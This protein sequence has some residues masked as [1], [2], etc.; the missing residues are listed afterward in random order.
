MVRIVALDDEICW[1]ETLRQITRE[2]FGQEEYE[3]FTP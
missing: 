1:I 3:F 2:F